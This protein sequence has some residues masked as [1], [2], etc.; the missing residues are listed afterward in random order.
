MPE[1]IVVAEKATK[2]YADLVALA[3]LDLKVKAG[4]AVALVGHNGSGKSTLLRMAA[5]L[6]DLSERRGRRSRASPRAPRRA[7]GQSSSSRRPGPVRRPQGP[8]AP[9]VHRRDSTAWPTWEEIA[10]DCSAASAC[11]TALDDL[12]SSFSRGL[13]QKTSIA[14][15]LIRPFRCCWS[16][17]PSSAS[18]P[19]A[20][21]PAGAARRGERRRSGTRRR[22]PRPAVRGA[23]HAVHR[24]ARRR[25]DPRRQS[26]AVRRPSLRRSVIPVWTSTWSTAP[27]SCS[28]TTSRC[29]R[30]VTSD[31]GGAATRGVVG[32]VPQL[33]E[34]GATHVGVATDH[35]IESFRNDLWAGYKDG[36]GRRPRAAR[37]S[38]RCRGGARAGRRRGVADGRVRGRRRHGAAAEVAAA[39]DRVE[40]VVICTPDKDLGQCVGG[41]VV[42]WTAA[43]TC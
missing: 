27:T 11:S 38:S 23:R 24:T 15:G 19:P 29:R 8:G 35:V 7:R 32:S 43:R 12:P 36:A 30:H 31:R 25:G 17:S 22:H 5:G 13:R 2:S 41:K 28:A 1:P 16:T 39:D 18:T 3:P 37:P 14:I 6:L 10:D 20:R 33:L 40:Q 26:H 9:R 42:Q 4:E 34:Q 21:P